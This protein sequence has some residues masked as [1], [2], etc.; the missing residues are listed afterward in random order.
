MESE[1]VSVIIPTYN[2][3]KFLLNAINSVKEQTY[4][5]VEIIIVNDGSTQEDYYNFDFTKLDSRIR[6]IH[7]K[8]NFRRKYKKSSPAANGRNICIEN[9]KGKYIAF[10]DDDD[11]W[12]PNKLELQIE[13][14]KEYDMVSC[15]SY[16]GRGPY[17]STQRYRLLSED[18]YYGII[19]SKFHKKNSNMIDNGFPD[20]FTLELQ[21]YHN[22]LITSSIIMT[23]ELIEKTGLFNVNKRNED[24]DYWKRALSLTKGCL[25]IQKPLIYY[26]NGHGD[27]RNY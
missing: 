2:R 7:L 10:L 27:G 6:M 25:Y 24:A 13:Q 18:V 19:K 9:S 15:Q 23:R 22:C 20:V 14:M 1:L 21:T 16:I 3:F 17:K 5:N 8:E 26:D 4:K 12:L 11:F